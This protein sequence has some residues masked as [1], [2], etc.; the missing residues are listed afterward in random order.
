MSTLDLIVGGVGVVVFFCVAVG[1]V[2]TL[3]N[4]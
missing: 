1:I 2:I 4:A 3:H